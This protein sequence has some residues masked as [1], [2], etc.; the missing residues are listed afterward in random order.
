MGAWHVP[1]GVSS[2]IVEVLADHD[3]VPV[4][5]RHRRCTVAS[6][7]PELTPDARLHQ[8]FVDSL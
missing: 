6:F 2:P 8:L 4:L 1:R 3:G 7:H 5:L